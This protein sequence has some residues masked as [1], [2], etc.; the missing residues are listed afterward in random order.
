[1]TSFVPPAPASQ[2]S[3]LLPW[4][5][6]TLLVLGC[7]TIY[8]R[9]G[10]FEFVA[11][12]DDYNI[13]FNPHL[14]PL[15]WER[16]QWAF[17]DWTYARRCMP[18]GWLGLS[19]VFSVTGL[20]PAGYHLAG[21]GFH[22]ANALLF[23]A[24]L[25]QLAAASRRETDGM[26]R[27][28]QTGWAVLVAAFWAWHPLR[29]ESVAWSSGLLY[30]QSEFFLLLAFL[31]FGR[32]P[33][34][35]ANR[36]GALVAFGLSLLSYPVA[37]GFAPVFAIMAGWQLKDW[38]RAW[39]I[40]FPFLLLSGA[41][42]VAN[43]VARTSADATFTP[44]ATLAEF[45]LAARAMQAAYSSVYFAR[46]PFWPVALT[47]A[48]P[49]LLDFDPSSA[50]FVL[51]AAVLVVLTAVC[52]GW[53][54][55][56]R[57][58]GPFWL[59]HLCVLVPLIG[60][61]ERVSFPS[62]RYAAF[63]QGVLAAALVVGLVRLR[64]APVRRVILAAGV[65]AVGFLGVLSARQTEI[66]RNTPA[67]FG[68]LARSL[69]PSVSPMLYF[70]RPAVVQFREGDAPGALA[71]LDRGIALLPA[72]ASLVTGRAD[73]QRQWTALQLKSV[74]TGAPP[75][76]APVVY[77]QQQLGLVAAQAG[78]LTVARAHLQLARA[79]APD[80]FEPAFN[81]ALVW[82]QLG[83]T[84]SALACYLWAEAHGSGHLRARSRAWALGR[85]AE[86]F[87]AAGESRLAEAA[88]ARAVRAGRD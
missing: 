53:P 79:G 49:V 67:L 48:N 21:L 11:F 20:N 14:G 60:M 23:F 73:L 65:F 52:L 85:I 70:L 59:A 47:P 41:A 77:M 27:A 29:V 13:L 84:R 82:L 68:C 33:G 5:L 55:A 16:L 56:R 75:G 72:N 57:T 81:L 63:P 88:R 78:D 38:R 66:W 15:S 80:F 86:Q 4:L 2:P 76:T 10:E 69:T 28:W 17:G 25:R 37:I 18:L 36:L 12:D 34:A 9:V 45:P 8:G 58:I 44:T 87:A 71:R 26:A 50:P 22:L 3:R 32:A 83:E 40:A 54:A 39:M 31:V 7:I 74:M 61:V 24:V 19:A 51:S 62:D 6:G 43:L 35:P 42:T 46:I 1:M 30:G 64:P